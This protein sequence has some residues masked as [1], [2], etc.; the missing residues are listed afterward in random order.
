MPMAMQNK[1]VQIVMN[2]LSDAKTK[3]ASLPML[4]KAGIE[5]FASKN[6][7][8][9]MLY[10]IDAKTKKL[11]SEVS[12]AENNEQIKKVYMAALAKG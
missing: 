6:T 1:D 7:G 4:K 5:K 9:G 12:L 11:I 8:T 2:D 3:A 10:F